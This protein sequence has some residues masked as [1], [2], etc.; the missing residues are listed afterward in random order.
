MP[1]EVQEVQVE[2][3]EGQEGARPGYMKTLL[4]VALIGAVTYCFICVFVD[5]D[6]DKDKDTRTENLGGVDG[7]RG[8]GAASSGG[9]LSRLLGGILGFNKSG[10]ARL[11]RDAGPG[12]TSGGI[13]PKHAGP[14]ESFMA[15]QGLADETEE[16]MMNLVIGLHKA[17]FQVAGISH[18][19]WTRVQ[20]EIFGDRASKARQYLE[21]NLYLECIGNET[22]PN[23]MNYPTWIRGDMKFEGFQNPNKL[24]EMIKQANQVEPR[25]MLKSPAEPNEVNLP[26]AK[27]LGST[28]SEVIPSKLTTED[29]YQVLKNMKENE[30][31]DLVA[32]VESDR[33]GAGIQLQNAPQTIEGDTGSTSNLGTA[34]NRAIE[35]EEAMVGSAAPVRKENVRGVSA[36]APLNVVDMPG[37][38]VMNLDLQHSDFQNRQGN[39]AR[40]SFE[41]HEPNRELA[42]QMVAQF[43]QAVD[44]AVLDPNAS[45]F[46]QTRYPQGTPITTGDPLVDKRIPVSQVEGVAKQLQQQQQQQ[47]Q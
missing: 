14:G 41:N 18:C 8:I 17:G 44:H 22:C 26:D 23:I 3:Q 47:R 21:K 45:S 15:D 32:K 46:S 27:H 29:I 31:S 43:N 20:R 2:E 36:Y 4:L 10:D 19:Y 42:R 24:R 13:V 16:S 12:A 5:D 7:E 40:A 11:V 6:K 37:S 38:S 39:E 33:S 30:F 25:Q 1:V 35:N 34:V 9:P 28:D